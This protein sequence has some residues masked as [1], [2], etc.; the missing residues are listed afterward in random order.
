VYPFRAWII[1]GGLAFAFAVVI[2][3]LVLLIPHVQESAAGALVPLLV[4]TVCF[5]AV[6]AYT[7]AFWQCTLLSAAAGEAGCVRWPG[8]DLALIL[9]SL[10]RSVMCLLAGPAL[11]VAVAFLFWYDAGDLAWIDHVLL[12]EL[13][14]TAAGY[15]LFALVAVAEKDRISAALPLSVLELLRRLPIQ[16]MSAVLLLSL[17]VG[18]HIA[19]SL[20]AIPEVHRTGFTGWFSLLVCW[21]NTLFWSVFLLRW[22]GVSSYRSRRAARPVQADQDIPQVLPVLGAAA[23]NR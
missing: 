22:L 18:G 5:I 6:L 20:E 13:I 21:G 9:L 14:V 7:C 15:W 3:F 23:H 1:I 8:M 10:Y 17:V 16:A 11:L 12:G 2:S 19:W 4:V